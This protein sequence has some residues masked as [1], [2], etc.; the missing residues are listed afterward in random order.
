MR[1]YFA[2]SSVPTP[3]EMRKMLA[4]SPEQAA[5]ARKLK[6][7]AVGGKKQLSKKQAPPGAVR[8]SLAKEKP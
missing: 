5:A 6:S 8:K 2:G 3:E 7:I 1:A 4:A